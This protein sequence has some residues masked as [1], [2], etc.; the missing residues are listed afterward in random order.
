[1]QSVAVTPPQTTRYWCQILVLLLGLAVSSA[2]LSESSQEASPTA[3][4][5]AG[6]QA[7]TEPLPVSRYEDVDITIDGILDEGIW[8][9]VQ[10]YDN[11]TVIE[12]DTLEPSR[13]RTESRFLYT[14]KGLYV[15]ILNEQPLDSLL[16]RLSIRD[17]VVTRDGIEFTL[18]PTGEGLYG[19]WFG[20]NLGGTLSDG[21]VLPERQI[22]KEWDGPWHGEAARTKDGWSAEMFLPWSMMAMPDGGDERV[23]SMFVARKVAH[24]D[25]NWSWPALPETGS[26]FMSALQPF[27]FSDVNPKRQFSA[28]PFTSAVHDRID[29]DTD[30]RV[31]ADIF[32]RPSSNLQLTIGINPDFGTVESDDVV[33][34]L[35]AFESFFPEKRLFFL[36]GSEI[37]VTSPRASVAARTSGGSARRTSSNFNPEPT[38]LVNTRRIGGAARRP[39]IPAGVSVAGVELSKP[40]ELA[41]A[42]KV[43]GQRGAF[44]YGVMAAFEDDSTFRGTL[45]NGDPVRLA[46]QGRDFG[47]ARLLYEDTSDG[48]KSLGWLS[49][50]VSHPDQDAV[51]HAMDGHYLSPTSRWKVDGQL[52]F[53]DVED[54]DGAG[55]FVSM[56]YIPKSGTT[57]S[58]GIDYFDRDLNVDDLGFIRR[59]DT[60]NFI[61]AYNYSTSDLD[62]FRN[63]TNSMF[64]S[65]EYNID[66]LVTRSGLFWRTSWTFHNLSQI[67]TEFDYF[68]ARWDDRNSRGNGT[69]RIPVRLVSEISYGSDTSKPVSV[70]AA[71]GRRQ[72]DSGGWRTTGKAGITFKP[73]HR[74]S[75]DLDV[76]YARRDD[77]LIHRGGRNFTTFD[78]T[79]W[80]PNLAMGIFF[81]ARQQLRLTLQWAG[82][83]ADQRSFFVVPSK[84]GRLV[85]VSRD[86]S[87]PSD[88]FTISRVTAQIRYRWEIAP[89]SDLFVVYTRGG[90]LPNRVDEEFGEL[91]HDSLL[92]PVLDFFVVKLRYRFGN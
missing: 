90:N 69:Y 87:E 50:L 47:V 42:A 84:P 52:M 79:D 3:S 17:Q 71:V 38:T 56:L 61:Y 75:F 23:M 18:D 88:N 60:I 85:E 55:G 28:Y 59:N 5:Q 36:E 91:F 33:V 31:G 48:R 82:I 68:P 83:R 77:W 89:L 45:A 74:L 78:A 54:V 35:T 70:S 12:P 22:T 76:N 39:D 1:M 4:N 8:Q 51:V 64:L 58:L 13:F 37:F 49:T 21:R 62:H 25:E 43:T 86:P 7:T 40:T 67:R 30:Y 15:S 16:E 34:N 53:S 19:Y 26:R 46:Q 73:N 66:G 9:E 80:Q 57:H 44:R 29:E 81:T 65:Q 20:V 6:S 63:R 24:L 92:E 41:G 11:M 32:W 10:A 72:E 2:S 27:R 14:D